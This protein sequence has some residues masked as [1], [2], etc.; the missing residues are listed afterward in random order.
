MFIP[1]Q[2][3]TLRKVFVA[4]FCAFS[5]FANSQPATEEL[6][7]P[8]PTASEFV[9]HINFPTN[10]YTGTPEIS[11]P[12]WTLK[13][14]T[15]SVPISLSY[16]ASGIKVEQTAGWV[17]LG[18]TLIAGGQITREVRGK[19]DDKVQTG[20]IN[21]IHEIYEDYISFKSWFDDFECNVKKNVVENNPYDLEPDVYSYSFPGG[22][23]KFV[24]D[25]VSSNPQQNK[26]EYITIPYDLIKIESISKSNIILDEWK[27]TDKN[28]IIYSFKDYD[29]NFDGQNIDNNY[30]STWYLNKIKDPINNDSIVFNYEPIDE[31]LDVQHSSTEY[32]SQGGGGQLEGNNTN[33][34]SKFIN[35]KGYKLQSIVT[36][37][38]RVDFKNSKTRSDYR[39]SKGALLQQIDIVD[40]TN[41]APMISYVFDYETVVTH[42]YVGA[43][44][45]QNRDYLFNRIFLNRVVKKV[46]GMNEEQVYLF[47]Y[48]D[49]N[50]LPPRNS[51][52]QDNWG[53]YNGK[54]NPSLIPSMI[55]Y[56][57]PT[58]YTYQGADKTPNLTD[59]QA[60][61]LQKITWPTGGSTEYVYELHDYGYIRSLAIPS[62]DGETYLKVIPAKYYAEGTI[63]PDFIASETLVIQKDQ[64]VD[65]SVSIPDFEF[66]GESYFFR[67]SNIRHPEI[68]FNVNR[69][70]K[71]Q[72]TEGEYQ[73]ETY[74]GGILEDTEE[75]KLPV[76]ITIDY[77]QYEEIVVN[78]KPIIAEVAGGLRIKQIRNYDNI[79]GEIIKKNYEYLMESDAFTEKPRSSG[80]LVNDPPNYKTTLS[81]IEEQ[82][83]GGP[84][85]FLYTLL[86]SRSV[87]SI[88]LS[89][90]SHVVYRQVTVYDDKTSD[91]EID[92]GKP[93][94]YYNG[95]SVYTYLTPFEFPDAASNIYPPLPGG[96]NE[97]KRGMLK[98]EQIYD[99]GDRLLKQ[100]YNDYNE[101]LSRYN[102]IRGHKFV[103]SKLAIGDIPY[104]GQDCPFEVDYVTYDITTGWKYLSSSISTEY[105]YNDEGVLINSQ[106][107][108]TNFG[109]DPST[110]ILTSKS[111]IRS[112]TEF[113]KFPETITEEYSY[114][115][116][117][118][119]K[120][121]QFIDN[122]LY[123]AKT[124]IKKR[125][126]SIIYDGIKINYNND[127]LPYS[128]E[129]WRNDRYEPEYS[130]TYN[131]DKRIIEYQ[132][133]DDIHVSI[134]WGYKSL[135]PVAKITGL[136]YATSA[137]LFSANELESIQNN[138]LSITQLRAL[139]S[140][141]YNSEWSADKNAFVKTFTYSPLKGVLTSTDENGKKTEYNYDG[142]G[143][144]LD[145]RDDSRNLLQTFDYHYKE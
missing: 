19:P 71:I 91:K 18:W 38:I 139:L 145:I 49:K 76:S 6:F 55:L 134:I 44:I 144:L 26:Y 4:I 64:F 85:N 58:P 42:N 20:Y 113:E 9:K 141:F 88:G 22:S 24:Y 81:S 103:F 96:K 108:K 106:I 12:I 100:V 2:K 136:N 65:I 14:K 111:D 130:Y 3:F 138:T 62:D 114:G 23:G 69:N 28:G 54:N 102:R 31:Y 41:Q 29:Y 50:R 43:T 107:T 109:Y 7:S 127:L 60:G 17:G 5:I 61:T 142:F 30:R 10:Y 84:M 92:L 63:Y 101:S 45:Y 94:K 16:H 126:N 86:H 39:D 131:D 82:P 95:R 77:K 74:L 27:I 1:K 72:L 110:T 34:S 143:R 37:L 124:K 122:F 123:T 79:T 51:F 46:S 70:K 133:V 35:V 135:F 25:Y 98:S 8:T 21:K 118:D 87:N 99:S 93:F 90:G 83:G 121:Q 120:K 40:K 47:N 125:H 36:A 132:K 97:W 13:S 52:A 32:I 56:N 11:I 80:V 117:D 67:I 73:I 89:A 59:A 57:G 48:F 66:K 116:Q 112:E 128:V 15:L 129:K 53:Y 119:E 140:G 104:I 78:G 68:F 105:S 33:Q 137:S 75:G 115:Y